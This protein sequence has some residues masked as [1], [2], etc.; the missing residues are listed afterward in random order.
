[1]GVYYA[2]GAVTIG[3]FAATLERDG[4]RMIGQLQQMERMGGLSALMDKLPANL[5]GKAQIVLF[6]WEPGASLWNPV[7]W[8]AAARWDRIGDGL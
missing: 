5:V 2:F 8:F 3:L 4:I 7:S 1:M 6:S